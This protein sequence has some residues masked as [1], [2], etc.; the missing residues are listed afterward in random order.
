[1]HLINGF[2]NEKEPSTGKE[3]DIKATSNRGGF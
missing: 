3:E 1:M 2:Y